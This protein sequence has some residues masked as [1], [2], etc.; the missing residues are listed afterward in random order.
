VRGVVG[1]LK[2]WAGRFRGFRPDDDAGEI[3]RRASHRSLRFERFTP[4]DVPL[5]RLYAGYVRHLL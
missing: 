3:L 4:E 1:R 2:P 5:Y